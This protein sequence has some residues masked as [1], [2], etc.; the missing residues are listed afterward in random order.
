M[1]EGEGEERERERIV[2]TLVNSLVLGGGDS[3]DW[4]FTRCSCGICSGCA[5]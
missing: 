4:A 3:A 5:L 2:V 1:V